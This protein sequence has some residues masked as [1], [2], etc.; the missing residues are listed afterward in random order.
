MV[1]IKHYS[2]ILNWCYE[3]I[4]HVT[5]KYTTSSSPFR[6][7]NYNLN[8]IKFPH[9]AC[10]MQRRLRRR[11]ILT[12]S[13]Y[14]P[15]HR[16]SPRR[17]FSVGLTSR[18][19]K[20]REGVIANVSH[21]TKIQE[22]SRTGNY[23]FITLSL[24]LH[25]NP[26]ISLQLSPPQTVQRNG[27]CGSCSYALFCVTLFFCDRNYCTGLEH[28]TFAGVGDWS[29][30]FSASFRSSDV[31]FY[32]GLSYCLFSSSAV[33]FGVLGGFSLVTMMYYYLVFVYG[34]T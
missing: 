31:L 27:I 18:D 28:C 1:Y 3:K 34:L 13:T 26:P 16:V 10:I 25:A 14:P 6:C 20:G 22:P 5:V 15:T 30:I 17:S 33:I 9:D 4:S 23:K 8:K 12:N 29:C 2:W 19:P 11:L 24:S 32:G 7:I 21:P